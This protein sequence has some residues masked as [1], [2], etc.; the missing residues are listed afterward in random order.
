MASPAA[1]APPPSPKPSASDNDY[2]SDEY[3]EIEEEIEVEEEVEVEEEIDSDE[4]EEDSTPVDENPD[5]DTYLS[6]EIDDDEEH[7]NSGSVTQGKPVSDPKTDI[8][9]E[10]KNSGDVKTSKSGEK[11]ELHVNGERTSRDT[12][13]KTPFHDSGE[14][15]HTKGSPSVGD[16]NTAMVITEAFRVKDSV[17]LPVTAET[18]QTAVEAAPNVIPMSTRSHDAKIRARDS[19]PTGERDGGNKKLRIACEFYAKGWCIKGNSCRF[20]HLKDGSDAAVQKVLDC[21]A[22]SN[23]CI[24]PQQSGENPKLKSETQKL[25]QSKDDKFSAGGSL[26]SHDNHHRPRIPSFEEFISKKSEPVKNDLLTELPYTHSRRP[27]SFGSSSRNTNASGTQ[28]LPERGLEQR[29]SVSSSFHQSISLVP[30]S[31]PESR[32]RDPVFGDTVPAKHKTELSS[33][34]WEPSVPFLPSHDITRNLLVKENVHN[35]IGDSISQKNV[36]SDQGSSIKNAKVQSKSSEEEE[37]RMSSVNVV[38]VD[39]SMK[40]DE[41]GLGVKSDSQ[42]QIESRVY[43]W[44]QSALVD[45]VKELLSPTWEKGLLSKDA[46]K[47]ILKKSVDKILSTLQRHQIPNTAESTKLYLSVSEAKIVKLVEAYIEKHG[48]S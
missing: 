30:H 8:L 5:D 46:Y 23:A 19:P 15:N 11:E 1:A 29:A 6:M 45:F 32:S 25:V 20:L 12:N 10:L 43:R 40:S 3:E 36:N 7:I 41:T 16:L 4:I 31:E 2:G 22:S 13:P 42:L 44:F 9:A 39:G 26:T 18:N 33:N 48:K 14:V 38:K 21:E 28:K 17:I 37:K 24:P 35:P 27:L 47:L 34:N